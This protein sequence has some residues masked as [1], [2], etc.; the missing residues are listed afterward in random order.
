MGWRRLKEK[1]EVEE[2]MDANA[3]KERLDW[4]SIAIF[5]VLLVTFV[6]ALRS[7]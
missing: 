6:V 1:H 4:I 3:P 2:G 7:R 5:V